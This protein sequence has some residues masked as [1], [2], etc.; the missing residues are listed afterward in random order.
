MKGDDGN[1]FIILHRWFNPAGVP[2]PEN[3]DSLV[4]SCFRPN[5]QGGQQQAQQQPPQQQGGF[6]QPPQQQQA[7]PP[8]PPGGDGVDDSIPFRQM[9]PLMGG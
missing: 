2:N 5:Q 1:E 4:A 8:N 9:H 7:A 6:Q 3:R